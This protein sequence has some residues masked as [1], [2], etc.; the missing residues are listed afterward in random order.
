VQCL[1][2]IS[3]KTAELISLHEKNEKHETHNNKTQKYVT[4]LATDH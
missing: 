1:E 3:H 2:L 4:K